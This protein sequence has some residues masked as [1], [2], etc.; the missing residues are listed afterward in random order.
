MEDPNASYVVMAVDGG[1][2]ALTTETVAPAVHLVEHPDD[3]RRN[4]VIRCYEEHYAGLLRLACLLVG[5]RQT[6]EDL[7]HEAFAR[8]YAN[9]TRVHD[10]RKVLAYLRAT[11]VNLAR[12]RHRRHLVA[13]KHETAAAPPAASA[14]DSALAGVH[15]S[16]V[17]AAL[18]RLPDRQRECLVLRHY[19][20]MSEGE[21]ADVLGVSVGSVRTH[22]KRGTATLERE[23]GGLR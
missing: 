22:T 13:V 4:A 8:L 14:E 19:L 6:A 15:R 17:I 20:R 7:V 1:R 16:D 11:V 10:E 23:L 18:H 3:Q 5:Q 2:G 9:R 21:I 12:G